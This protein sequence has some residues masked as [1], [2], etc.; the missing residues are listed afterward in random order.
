MQG[1]I[2]A[3]AGKR[4]VHHLPR[5]IGAWLAG[6]YDNDRLVSRAAQ[7]SF[8]HVFSS[9]ERRRNVWKVYL[10]P[11]LEHSRASILRETVRTLS[12]ERTVS[13]DDAEGKYARVVATGISLLQNILSK[14]FCQGKRA[15]LTEFLAQV[16]GN[17]F[18]K[19]QPL[20]A[21]ILSDTQ[22]WTNA[23]Y[24]DPFVRRS[25]YK[26]LCT[27]LDKQMGITGPRLV[28]MNLF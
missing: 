23:S 27:C 6:T 3:S 12:D 16:D 19:E 14:R 10:R 7:E 20:L 17:D 2:V 21:E 4:S 18:A 26:L 9:E 22:L 1:Q 28:G 25:V 15:K 11:I 24:K 13:V 8:Q 5:V